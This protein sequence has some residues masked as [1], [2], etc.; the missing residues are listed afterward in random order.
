MPLQAP[1]QPANW[2]PVAA[3]AISVMAVLLAKLAEATPQ[4]AKQLKPL[5]ELVT[6]PTPAPD[7]LRVINRVAAATLKF[8]VTLRL[9]FILTVQLLVLPLQ[10]PLQ[11]AKLLPEAGFAASAT[12]VPA[13]KLAVQLLPQSMPAGVL[14]TVPLPV[15]WRETDRA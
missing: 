4:S 2:L 10:A 8:A 5:G 11:P 3:C 6:L 12:C 13:A 9:L 7:L 14:L 15:P 1:L